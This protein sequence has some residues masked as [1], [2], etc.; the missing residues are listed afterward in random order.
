MRRHKYRNTLGTAS[1]HAFANLVEELLSSLLLNITQ[2]RHLQQLDRDGIDV[3]QFDSETFGVR[4]AVQCKGYEREWHSHRVKDL[5]NEIKKFIR[6][7]E[8]VCEYWLVLNR[9]V[10]DPDDRRSIEGTLT[11]IV[12]A[13][14]AKT[15]LLLDLD[16]FINVLSER[17]IQ[18][19]RQLSGTARQSFRDTYQAHLET[20]EYLPNVPFLK[21]NE[22]CVNP[23]VHIASTLR[24]Y[25]NNSRPGHTGPYRKTPRFLIT[26]SFGFG[27]TVGLHTL[28]DLWAAEHEDVFFFPA[29]NLS[30]QAF[31]N[32]A[33][34]L[35]DIMAHIVDDDLAS[36][37]LAMAIL[38]DACK[39][40]FRSRYPLL[41]IDAIDE[42]LFWHEPERLEMLWRSVEQLGIP[43][44]VTVR[45]ELYQSRPK[46]FVSASTPGF[47]SHIALADWDHTLMTQFLDLFAARQ[48]G[49]PPH[50][51]GTL[52]DT[53]ARNEYE[54][55][56]GDI[57]KRPLFLG[58]LAEDAWGGEDPEEVLFRLYGKYFRK[59]LERDWV[60]IAA[61]DRVVRSG[62]VAR[63]YG[64]EQAAEELIWMMQRLALDIHDASD[65]A[66]QGGT[67]IEEQALRT[68]VSTTIGPIEM[69]EEVLFASLI[70]PAGRDPVSRRRLYRFAHKSFLDWFMARALVEE[71]RSAEFATTSVATRAFGEAMSAALDRGEALP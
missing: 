25:I 42:S 66:E 54:H 21:D 34:L 29:V 36:S 1:G 41:L 48:C 61:P 53:V 62:E 24:S 3:Y 18:K 35:A 40:E 65:A 16:R 26:G 6:R 31:V 2:S 10:T 59:K 44:A 57:P 47:F 32:S 8:P 22:L 14:K 23:T 4:L 7:S 68:C 17:A 52:R 49:T 20:V 9:S 15:A 12:A 39:R 60:S 43:A 70:Q 45:D 50:T 19:F 46:E 37:D 58:M 55:R 33:G 13:G 5:T 27:K 64:K 63:R 38:R 69:I 71:G 56:Y 28:G 11:E 67:L 30:E 51:F